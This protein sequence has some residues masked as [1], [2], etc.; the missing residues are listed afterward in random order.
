ML[1]LRIE[2]LVIGDAGIEKASPSLSAL[3][4]S[5]NNSTSLNNCIY[6]YNCTVD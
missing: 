3:S 4:G 6:R 5:P 1:A 2:E